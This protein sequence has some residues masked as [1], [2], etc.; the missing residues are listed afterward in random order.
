MIETPTRW[1]NFLTGDELLRLGNIG[2]AELI[3]GRIMPRHFKTVQNGI[4][5]GNF[6]ESLGRHTRR[7]K[8]GR[9]HIGGIGI[10]TH[11]HPDIIRAADVAYISNERFAQQKRKGGYLDIAPEL[12]VEVLSPDDCWQ[13][14]MHKMREYFGVGV[15]LVWVA[16]P[17]EQVVY[18]YRSPTDVREFKSGDS[19]TADAILNGFAVP[20]ADLFEQ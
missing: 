12:V 7:I 18:V 10:Y 4:C 9:I 5:A 19:L 6:A 15:Q 1:P 11:R 16:D 13:E 3:A 2:P 8:Q 20:V 14:V 17:D